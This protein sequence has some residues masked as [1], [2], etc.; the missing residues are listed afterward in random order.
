MKT[1][2]AVVAEFVGTAFLLAAVVGSGIMAQRLCG[3]N[4]GLAL[5]ANALAT[6]G[7]LVALIIA[8]GSV[9]GAHF[10]PVVTLASALRDKNWSI[11]LPYVCAQL[12]GAL[13][14][15]ALANL[16]FGLPAFAVSHHERS[17]AA[18]VVSEFVATFGL[19]AVIWGCARS[20]PDAAPY[21]VA[22][23]IVGAYWFTPS[24]SF[25]N[26]AVAIARSLTD[27]FSGIRPID[28]PPFVLAQ[29]AGGIA[30]TLLFVWFGMRADE[31]VV[32]PQ[33]EAA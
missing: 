22:A 19:L 10:N 13:A 17:G 33:T 16:M 26:P 21:A 29:I 23:Y 6:G 30:A 3:G 2:R 8:F 20:R 18:M 9:S 14:G 11:V 7:A 5:L 32:V 12:L 24:T 31:S 27:T 15:T 1:Y 28:V 4:V 25:A